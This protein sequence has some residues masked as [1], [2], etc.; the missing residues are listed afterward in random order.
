MKP[1]VGV[2]VYSIYVITGPDGVYVGETRNLQRRW[3]KH[4][5]VAR[6]GDGRALYVSMRRHGS[7]AFSV[8]VV[9][10]A[11]NHADALATELTVANQ[12]ADGGARVFNLNR[13]S[14]AEEIATGV[15]FTPVTDPRLALS[16]WLRQRPMVESA[17]ILGCDRS[18]LT[19]W[20]NG[21][22]KPNLTYALRI[23]DVA[24]IQ[25]TA[26]LGGSR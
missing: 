20:S 9:A 8:E 18:A 26:W 13:H 6:R 5:S 17:A 22:C 23:Q 11:K 7:D 3:W 14:V 19:H 16:R 21:R 15:L 2:A 10:Q 24:G 4:E 12:L 25:A 1:A